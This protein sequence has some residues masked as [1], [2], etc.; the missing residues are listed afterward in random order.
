MS[1][2]RI[3]CDAKGEIR[4]DGAIVGHITFSS[5]LGDAP[6]RE[7]MEC[8]ATCRFVGDVFDDW[9]AHAS[10]LMALYDDVNWDEAIACA[11]DE[12]RSSR[13]GER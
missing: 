8:L 4:F 7:L 1:Y 2:P 6:I 9:V 13:R 10:E 3:T 11:V 5:P 12:I